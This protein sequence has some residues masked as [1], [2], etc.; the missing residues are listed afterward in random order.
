MGGSVTGPRLHWL[1]AVLVAA[2]FCASPSLAGA[3]TIDVN[4]TE[5][6][7][8]P[9]DGKCSLFEA[10]H[11]AD[12]TSPSGAVAGECP[13]GSSARDTINLP[14][15]GYSATGLELRGDHGPVTIAGAGAAT[16]VISLLIPAIPDTTFNRL[17]AVTGPGG[18]VIQ[19]VSLT[20]G[21]QGVL[22][23]DPG[24]TFE[25]AAIYNTGVLTVARCILHHNDAHGTGADGGAIFN[26]GSLSVV[27]STFAHNLA[28]NADP[29]TGS[30][31]GAAGANGSPGATGGTGSGSN[32]GNGGNG[33]AIANTGAL[34]VERSIFTDNEAGWGGQAGNGTG[35]VGGNGA[36]VGSGGGQ[37]GPGLG[38]AGGTGGSGG[39]IWSAGGASTSLTVADS[40]F[41]G[42]GAG[43]GGTG[44]TGTGGSGGHGADGG[45]G[46]GGPGGI[47]GLGQGGAGGRGGSGGGIYIRTADPSV[48]ATLL[49]KNSVLSGNTSGRGG[50]GGAG[51]G[52][53]AG[54]PGTGA[55]ARNGSTGGQGTGGDGGRAG[56]GGSYAHDAVIDTTL[57]N[58]A[59]PG[60]ENLTLT[61]NTTENGGAGG[62]AT[63]GQ[64]TAGTAGGSQGAAGAA[65][66]GNGGS[67]GMGGGASY[68]VLQASH[69]TVSANAL[70]AGGAGGSPGGGAGAGGSYGGLFFDGPTDSTGTGTL[71]TTPKVLESSVIASNAGTNCSPP[72]LTGSNNVSFPDSSCGGDSGDPML[73][74]PADN[75]GP[76]QTQALGSGSSARDRV[77]SGGV[78]ATTDQRGVLRAMPGGC[79]AGAYE[80]APPAATTGAATAITTG[81]A[82]LAGTVNPNLRA[83]SYHFEF[84]PTDSYGESTGTQSAGAGNLPAQAAADLSGLAPATTYH[85]RLVAT[86]AEGS[87]DG[88]DR[89]FT[90]TP[91][92]ESG[93]GSAGDPVGP[94]ETSAPGSGTATTPPAADKTTPLLTGVVLPS[95]KPRKSSALK[96]TLS[97]AAQVTMTVELVEAGRRDGTRCV[98]PTRPNARG[99]H[100]DRFTR[101]AR[102]SMRGAPGANRKI[103]TRRIGRRTL[104]PGRYRLTLVAV[105]A[106][107]NRSAVRRLTFKVA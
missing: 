12:G 59:L 77:A 14:P 54:T 15:G 23:P 22:F 17:F 84:G 13:A 86:N 9:T 90:T 94:A 62:P 34:T 48:G 26:T 19:D 25:G 60:L 37:G 5:S 63:P 88:A 69:L 89:T 80:V 41:S 64:G 18:H 104:G 85:Y 66:G 55:L 43:F 49:I 99:K 11:A 103:I 53:A 44:G 82:T 7:S 68:D 16:T 107:G 67:G 40:T 36:N 21:G 1:P 45:I 78:C 35:G 97:E 3:S 98:K 47:G 30:S 74:P 101:P 24:V 83:S 100:C 42:N 57:A 6:E 61:A 46:I 76:T 95:L 71:V 56:S 79:D 93:G 96:F 102:L 39:A 58:Q 29:V 72:G 4:T 31:T 52:G 33:G 38:G 20:G 50:L 81:A 28:G 70:G 65:T 32:G 51:T 8:T 106:A 105:D 92:A 73:Q 87:T 10:V 91:L 27:D 75:G 2:C